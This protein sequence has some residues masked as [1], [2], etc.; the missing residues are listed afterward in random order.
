MKKFTKYLLITILIFF[1]IPLIFFIGFKTITGKFIDENSVEINLNKQEFLPYETLQIEIIG[2]FTSPIVANDIKIK[3]EGLIMPAQFYV[4]KISPSSYFAYAILGLSPGDYNLTITAN[5]PTGVGIFEREIKILDISNSYYL[6]LLNSIKDRWFLLNN[7][8]LIY[9]QSAIRGIDKFQDEKALNELLPRLETFN[10]IEKALALIVIDSENEAWLLQKTKLMNYFLAIQDNSVGMFKANIKT[11]IDAE[12]EVNGVEERIDNSEKDI[13][14]NFLNASSLNLTLYCFKMNGED[15]INASVDDI[16][17][18]NASLIKEYFGNKKEYSFNKT[19]EEKD[20]ILALKFSLNKEFGSV[21]NDSI[22]TSLVLISFIDNNIN[23]YSSV[24]W[25][26]KQND[27]V[28]KNIALAYLNNADAINYLVS[29]Q[30]YS[31]ALPQDSGFSAAEISCL[32][33]KYGNMPTRSLLYNWIKSNINSFNIKDKSACLDLALTKQDVINVLP[34]IVKTKTGGSFDLYLGN[35]GISDANAEIR[36]I[37]LNLNASIEIKKDQ[38]KKVAITVPSLTSAKDYVEDKI[39]IYYKNNSYS[40]PIIIFIEANATAENITKINE[41]ETY[42]VIINQTGEEINETKRMID[43][44]KIEP[45]KIEVNVANETQTKIKLKNIGKEKIENIIVWSSA[46]LFGVV[47]NIQPSII[48]E[49]NAGEEKEITIVFDKGSLPSYE[50]SITIEGVAN[51]VNYKRDVFV[52]LSSPLPQVIGLPSCTEL[53]GTICKADEKCSGALKSSK[54][55]TCCVGKCSGK[56]TKQILGIIFILIGIII[57][58]AAIIV[59][60]RKPK[61]KRIEE[62]IKRIQEKEAEKKLQGGAGGAGT[63]K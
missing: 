34:G 42:K 46:S 29:K 58:A 38:T 55:G 54:E 36:N 37:L 12:C 49:L 21:N 9:A 53:N 1:I 14:V 2:N 63:F 13:I 51:G 25:L 8:E 23:Q 52:K 28:I 61:G 60:K 32:A 17:K 22:L 16:K 30:G 57:I 44:F 48:N 15:K 47:K 43:I 56:K 39:S 6:D 31:G 3:R 33:Y 50:G 11:N 20:N 24:N 10:D 40:V 35:K 26:K 41:T 7:K 45:E 62:V 59:L 18:V 19:I 5:F 27:S 4:E